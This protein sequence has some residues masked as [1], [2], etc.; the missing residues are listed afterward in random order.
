MAVGIVPLLGWAPKIRRR[1]TTWLRRQVSIYSRLWGRWSTILS[2]RDGWWKCIQN[3]LGSGW[4]GGSSRGLRERWLPS[5]CSCSC[6]RWLSNSPKR[7]TTAWYLREI[8]KRLWGE[9]VSRSLTKEAV[10]LTNIR[11]ILWNRQESKGLKRSAI[12]PQLRFCTAGLA[13]CLFGWS[14]LHF[15]ITERNENLFFFFAKFFMKWKTRKYEWETTKEGRN[16]NSFISPPPR[17]NPY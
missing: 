1:E 7:V 9:R 4:K 12:V 11:G 17:D 13:L 5:R 6:Y 16:Y 3:I 2:L 8:T 15:C 10:L 14:N